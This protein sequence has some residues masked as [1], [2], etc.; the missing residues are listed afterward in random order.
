[1]VLLGTL[2]G[3]SEFTPRTVLF[4]AVLLI[5]VRPL[6]VRLG[7]GHPTVAP[8]QRRAVELFAARGAAALYCLA[9][10]PAHDLPASFGRQLQSA[11]L[12]VIVISVISGAVSALTAGKPNPG[13]AL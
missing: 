9:L 1:M 7:L 5:L 2:L 13:A 11:V 10:V 8:A 12:V 3:A 6:A 4:A